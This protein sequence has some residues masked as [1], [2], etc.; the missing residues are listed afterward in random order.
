MKNNKK[1]IIPSLDAV[2][3]ER[4]HLQKQKRFRKAF[5]N[6]VST[7]IVVAS[8]AVLISTLFVSILQVSGTSMEP[9]LNDGDLIVVSKSS[10][11]ETGD[12]IGFYYQNKVL[13]KRV[14]GLPGDYINIDED[15]NVF[16]NGEALDEPYLIEPGL[17]ISD[18][19]YPYQ[20]PDKRIFVLGDNRVTSIDSR[21]KQVGAIENE[22]VVG[23]VLLKIWPFK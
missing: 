11:F 20:V 12:L 14:I 22:Q 18:I 17:G 6:T 19:K 16:V 23:K 1:I 9:N 7:L 4:E 5:K 8:V 15:G 3:H 2:A 10:K 13:L 21:S